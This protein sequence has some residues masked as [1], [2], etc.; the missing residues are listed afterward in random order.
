MIQ[1][2]D[3]LGA[4][5]W[6]TLLAGVMAAIPAWVAAVAAIL[7]VVAAGAALWYA[8][9]QIVEAQKSRELTRE[10]D[11]ERSQPYVVLFAEASAVSPLFIDLVVRNFGP[12]AARHVRIHIDP[13]PTRAWPNRG[14]KVE[15]PGLIPIL[16]PGQEWRT[17]WDS[18]AERASTDLPDTHVGAVTYEGVRGM[19]QSTPVL[20]D[21]RVFKNRRW[22]EERGIH[23]AAVAL[24]DIRSTLKGWNER[25]TLRVTA[26]NGDAADANLR[27]AREDYFG[28]QRRAAPGE[29]SRE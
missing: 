8:H 24:R 13:W 22:M 15:L 10:L 2:N 27:E 20:L 21:W 12:T 7:T 16:A 9:G 11:V 26:R 17:T 1:L 6:A 23:D 5:A 19:P 14:E 18:S 25:N 3:R 29:A 4:E 28:G